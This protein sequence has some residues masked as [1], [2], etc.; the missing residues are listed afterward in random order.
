[1]KDQSGSFLS[2]TLFIP[3]STL[4]LD[5]GDGSRMKGI[6][7]VTISYFIPLIDNGL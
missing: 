5:E 7:S 2:L 3:I 6:Q 1:M 4:E